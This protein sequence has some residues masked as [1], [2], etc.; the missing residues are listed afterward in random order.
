MIVNNTEQPIYYRYDEG[1]LHVWIGKKATGSF[2]VKVQGSIPVAFDFEGDVTIKE[3]K[4]GKQIFS[5]YEGL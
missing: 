1:I 5:E 4:K 2:K 3:V